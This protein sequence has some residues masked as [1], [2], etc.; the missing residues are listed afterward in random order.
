MPTQC[1]RL[2]TE[3]QKG[4]KLTQRQMFDELRIGNHTGRISD[5]RK[6]GHIIRCDDKQTEQGVTGLYSLDLGPSEAILAPK[7]EDKSKVTR[8][9]C[10]G[11]REK[12]CHPFKLYG[13]H[14]E[15]EAICDVH[16]EKGHKLKD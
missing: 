6:K 14:T 16:F 4:R 3:L 2:L 9:W 10:G 12:A 7:T 15:E 5:L 8:Y 11:G 1:E 13:E